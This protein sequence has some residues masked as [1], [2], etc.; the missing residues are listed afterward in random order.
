MAA[1]DR[2]VVRGTHGYHPL[3]SDLEVMLQSGGFDQLLVF[4]SG[5][6]DVVEYVREIRIVTQLK[7]RTQSGKLS[8]FSE[9]LSENGISVDKFLAL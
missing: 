1:P 6:K 3:A 5:I 7:I 9:G 4:G 2:E 8:A